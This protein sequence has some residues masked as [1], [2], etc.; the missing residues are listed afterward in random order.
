M[1]DPLALGCLTAVKAREVW[2]HEALEFIHPGTTQERQLRLPGYDPE[3]LIEPGTKTRD[4]YALGA[5]DP[6]RVRYVVDDGHFTLLA[7]AVGGELGGRVGVAPRLFLKKL[8]ADDL[9]RVDLFPDFGPRRDYRLAV[10]EGELTAVEVVARALGDR[11]A[12]PRV[13]DIDLEL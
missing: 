10:T 13:D 11:R 2:P 5:K 8:I 9:D 6:E 1:V 4:I 7:E 3:S 12:A